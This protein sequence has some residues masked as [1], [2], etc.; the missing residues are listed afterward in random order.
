M[1]LSSGGLLK[2]GGVVILQL[3]GGNSKMLGRLSQEITKLRYFKVV[4][5]VRD[6][7]GRD[8]CL[9]LKRKSEVV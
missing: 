3:P 1:T 2:P 6:E 9:V 8:R 4:E 7:R 5:V